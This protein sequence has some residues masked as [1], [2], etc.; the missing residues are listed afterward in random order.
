MLF[1]T[2]EALAKNEYY[3]ASKVLKCIFNIFNNLINASK[4]LKQKILYLVD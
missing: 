2:F 1:C 3:N 4:V